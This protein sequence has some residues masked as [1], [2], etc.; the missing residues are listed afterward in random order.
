MSAHHHQT[1]EVDY[2]MRTD[3][4]PVYVGYAD[5]GSSPD[6][7]APVWSIFRVDYD[8]GGNFVQKVW[9]KLSGENRGNTLYNKVW[10]DRGTYT[11]D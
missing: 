6:V 8:L 10:N 5:P 7:A 3:G 1:I 2:A 9:A 4:Q 11:Y